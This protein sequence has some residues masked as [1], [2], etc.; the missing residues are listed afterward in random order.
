MKHSVAQLQSK[1]AYLLLC[2]SAVAICVYKCIIVVR[3]RVYSYNSI[4]LAK[5]ANFCKK[6]CRSRDY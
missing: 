5:T 4:S 6:N 1:N 3:A 2:A